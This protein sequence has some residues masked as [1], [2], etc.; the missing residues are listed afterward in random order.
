MSYGRRWLFVLMVSALGWVLSFESVAGRYQQSAKKALP[1]IIYGDVLAEDAWQVYGNRLVCRLQHNLSLYGVA[2]F[3]Q[4]AGSDD[5]GFK[6]S[7]IQY[8]RLDDVAALLSMPPPWKKA[9][10]IKKLSMVPLHTG[11]VPIRLN[12]ALSQ[13]VLDELQEGMQARFTYRSTVN[14]PPVAIDLSPLNFRKAYGVYLACVDKL[15]PFNFSEIRYSVVRF[16]SEG[17]ILTE[18]VRYQLDRIKDYL[19]ADKTVIRVYIDGYADDSGTRAHNIH[20]SQ[21]RAEKIGKYFE[22]HGVAKDILRVWWHGERAPIADNS[23]VDGRA[24]NR[25]VTIRLVR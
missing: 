2:A 14:S 16:P 12:N 24:K 22:S 1:Q 10:A 19:N 8:Q 17:L 13:Q 23:T 3:K 5:V 21:S 18:D 25:R 9:V 6:L 4:S 7:S 15:L 11:R 20:L